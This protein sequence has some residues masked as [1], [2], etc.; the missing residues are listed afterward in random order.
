LRDD[1]IAEKN[2]GGVKKGVVVESGAARLECGRD[3]KEG[4]GGALYIGGRISGS[5][6]VG[7]NKRRQGWPRG[8]A[9]QYASLRRLGNPPWH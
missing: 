7:R 2:E 9:R 3:E 5:E 1:D 6:G 8:H 4:V